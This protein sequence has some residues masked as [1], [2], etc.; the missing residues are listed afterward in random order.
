MENE[1]VYWADHLSEISEDG[2]EQSDEDDNDILPQ[3]FL[4]LKM[5]Q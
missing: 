5:F 3:K 1:L 2:L 4:I